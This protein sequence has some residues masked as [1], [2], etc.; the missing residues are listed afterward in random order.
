MVELPA[1]TVTFLFTDIEGSTKLLHDLGDALDGGFC[2]FFHWFLRC[3][4]LL[5]QQEFAAVRRL[6]DEAHGL[7]L[8]L[9]DFSYCPGDDLDRAFGHQ[10]SLAHDSHPIGGLLDL[11]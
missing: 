3:A 11:R 10:L 7:D 2:G 5:E 4:V 6:V 8:Q 9:T 1:G